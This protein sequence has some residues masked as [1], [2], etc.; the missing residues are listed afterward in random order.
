[1]IN[2]VHDGKIEYIE[3]L[4]PGKGGR[5]IYQCRDCGQL[6]DLADTH[7]LYMSAADIE[8]AVKDAIQRRLDD[9]VA[10]LQARLKY[11]R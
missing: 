10:D 8:L 7:S 6:F 4:S 11:Y 9:I 5:E 2:C 1:M 3:S